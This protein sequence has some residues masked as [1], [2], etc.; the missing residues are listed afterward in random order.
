MLLPPAILS[1]IWDREREKQ[2]VQLLP[3]VHLRRWQLPHKAGLPSTSSGV[4]MH[5]LQMEPEMRR[6]REIYF[7]KAADV[8]NGTLPVLLYRSVLPP[9]TSRKTNAVRE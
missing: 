8:P 2:E 3:S 4:S 9:H 6:V 1:S 5:N 7:E